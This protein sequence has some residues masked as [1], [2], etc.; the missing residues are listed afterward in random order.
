MNDDVDDLTGRLDNVKHNREIQKKLFDTTGEAYEVL[1]TSKDVRLMHVDEKGHYHF[2]HFNSEKHRTHAKKSIKQR[3]RVIDE[4]EADHTFVSVSPSCV[5]VYHRA[6]VWQCRRYKGKVWELEDSDRSRPISKKIPRP[7]GKKDKRE[8]REWR[9]YA[10]V[11]D[12]DRSSN[13]TPE[14]PLLAANTPGE[15]GQHHRA[16]QSFYHDVK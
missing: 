8:T 7:G 14:E 13:A 6:G 16:H 2:A 5:T 12:S 1:I 4:E 3:W 10:D 9:L 11:D 15:K